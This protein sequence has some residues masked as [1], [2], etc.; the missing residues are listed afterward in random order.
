MPTQPP[1]GTGWLAGT[2]GGAEGCGAE[3]GGDRGRGRGA[4][5][6]GGGY[7]GGG[8]VG[9]GADEVQRGRVPLR[10]AQAEMHLPDVRP[11]RPPRQEQRVAPAVNVLAQQQLQHARRELPA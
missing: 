3:G 2:G 6:E 7:F 9:R 11:V 10:V 8:R 1:D 4:V 5:G